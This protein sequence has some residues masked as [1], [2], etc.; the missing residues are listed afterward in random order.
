[1][2]RIA[3]VLFP[4][5]LLALLG[6]ALLRVTVGSD[7]YLQYVKE[8]L[9][10]PLVVSGVL[11]VLVGIVNAVHGLTPPREPVLRFS[12]AADGS[13]QWHRAGHTPDEGG[14][15][16]G[17]GHGHANGG[18]HG[19]GSGHGHGGAPG[20]GGAHGHG[21]G[22]APRVAGLLAVP[23]VALLF[24]APPALGAFTA[25]REGTTA[26]V[27][28]V[29]YAGLAERPTTPMSL[30]EFIGRSHD[31]AKSLEGRTV[32]LTGFAAPGSQAGEWYLNRLTVNCCAAD[33]RRLRV[34]VTGTTAAPAT[35]SWVEVTGVWRPVPGAAAT[36]APR[37]EVREVKPVQAP[38]NPYRDVPP[39]EGG[40]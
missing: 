18:E 37:L 21:H 7:V 19:H 4:S 28:Q 38:R 3:R 33:A 1:M 32:R 14:D 29:A 34:Q 40:S 30:T 24:F 22:G 31:P 36:A 20:H 11:L 17:Y 2:S 16:H 6:A 10:V 25:Q 35:D 13:A 23:A 12:R 9:H 5:L 39:G 26:P 15:A 8:G 27:E